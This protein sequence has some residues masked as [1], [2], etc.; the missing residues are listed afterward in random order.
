MD[1]VISV[2]AGRPASLLKIVQQ[3]LGDLSGRRV[4]LLGLTFKSGTDDLRDSPALSVLKLL[5][6]A[7]S[8][9]VA[10]DPLVDPKART[11]I[12]ERAEVVDTAE[13]ALNGA[14]VA[15]IAT[16]WPEFAKLDW[17]AIAATMQQP[18]IVDGRNLLRRVTLPAS[19]KY[20]RIGHFGEAEAMP[21]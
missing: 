20:Y 17:H 15:I 12:D 1:A 4:A 8:K 2:N 16:G 9:V 5:L 14:D 3:S 18:I 13:S 19:M 11:G 7:G 10:F 6:D 21:A